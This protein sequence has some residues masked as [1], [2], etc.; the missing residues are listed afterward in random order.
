MHLLKKIDILQKLK[1]ALSLALWKSYVMKKTVKS[2]IF[3][4]VSIIF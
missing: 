3:S 1:K 2:N 4:E